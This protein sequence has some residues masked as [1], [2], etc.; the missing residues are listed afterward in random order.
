MER[1]H[2]V[3]LRFCLHLES[4]SACL[5]SR[6]IAVRENTHS[7]QVIV[8]IRINFLLLICRQNTFT[9]LEKWCTSCLSPIV[10]KWSEDQKAANQPNPVLHSHYMARTTC[11]APSQT[12]TLLTHNNMIREKDSRTEV[13]RSRLLQLKEPLL[14]PTGLFQVIPG[15][16]PD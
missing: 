14:L 4:V 6:Y 5:R 7:L 10:C 3:R 15:T 13:V 8:L 11:R 16:W 9:I 1:Q 12:N 2:R